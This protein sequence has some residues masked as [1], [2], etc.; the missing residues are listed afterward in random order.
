MGRSGDL[1][2]HPDA[3]CALIVQ[4]KKSFTGQQ[5]FPFAGPKPAPLL[6]FRDPGLKPLRDKGFSRPGDFSPV[7]RIH[8][9][10]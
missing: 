6:H 2:P 8:T 7:F 10:R 5:A 1:L 9:I 3:S 4:K